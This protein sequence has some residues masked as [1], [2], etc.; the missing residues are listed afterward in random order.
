MVASVGAFRRRFGEE[1]GSVMDRAGDHKDHT[2]MDVTGVDDDSELD[3]TSSNN[4]DSA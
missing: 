2:V 4:K 3:K 1:T